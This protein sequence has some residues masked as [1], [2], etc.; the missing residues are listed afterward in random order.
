MSFLSYAQ[1]LEDVVLWRALGHIENGIYVDVGA[2]DPDEHSVTKAFYDLGWSGINIEPLEEHFDHLVTARGRDLNLR[3][4]ASS[5]AG[6]CTLHA[7]AGSGLSTL[8]ATVAERH[9]QAGWGVAPVIV[10]ALPLS[11]VLRDHL[12]ETIHFLKIDVEGAEKEVIEGFD[13]NGTRPW[14]ILVESTAPLSPQS[15]SDDWEPVL[16][17]GGYEFAY[18]DGLNR[19]YVAKEKSE[20]AA[21]IAIPPNVFD[22][23][24]RAQDSR[25]QIALDR[26]RS[27]T[28]R[29]REEVDRLGVLLIHRGQEIEAA[30]VRAAASEARVADALRKQRELERTINRA[31]ANADLLRASLATQREVVQELEKLVEQANQEI[32]ALRL[33]EAA[34]RESE[35][36]LLASE[37]ALRASE[38]ARRASEIEQAAAAAAARANEDL[39]HASAAAQR[40]QAAKAAHLQYRLQATLASHSWRLTLPIRT[41]SHFLR[42]NAKK[43]IR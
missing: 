9:A 39:L 24:V 34:Q 1:N 37:E 25:V 38:A 30:D 43:L 22:D 40:E 32:A 33:S 31:D 15:T 6:L 17:E 35:A 16:I 5:Q 4:A 19:F 11:S 12:Y 29:L 28:H 21:S 13:F 7:I 2:A 20:L 3:V 23:F 27:E 14:I 18:F 26:E 10:P 41:T 8:D 42:M 36:A